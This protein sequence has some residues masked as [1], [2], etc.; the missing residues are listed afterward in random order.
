ML[1]LSRPWALFGSKFW[2]ILALSSSGKITGKN[3]KCGVFLDISK[4]FDKVWQKVPYTNFKKSDVP[5]N[6]PDANTDFL[7]WWKQRVAL[8]WQFFSWTSIKPGVHQGSR[9]EPFLYLN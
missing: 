6:L 9:L 7:N 1:I 4:A 3:Y 5:G 2:I 8:N